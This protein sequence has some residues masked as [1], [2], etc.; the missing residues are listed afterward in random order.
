MAH[1]ESSRTV[2]CGECG[3]P[4]P[5]EWSS[6][7]DNER[8]RCPTCGS[9]KIDV[10]VEL[11]DQLQSGTATRVGREAALSRWVLDR[12]TQH[13]LAI[14]VRAALRCLWFPICETRH[15]EQLSLMG[16]RLC[17]LG[18]L[19]A[20]D[21]EPQPRAPSRQLTRSTNQKQ[22]PGSEAATLWGDLS[23]V[24]VSAGRE[25]TVFAD[26]V[27][28]VARHA[29][30]II[31]NPAD[32]EDSWTELHADIDVMFDQPGEAL[33]KTELFSS[34]A[35][36]Y[37]LEEVK[38]SNRRY[39]EN[40]LTFLADWYESTIA[41]HVDPKLLTEV[42]GIPDAD[43]A[44]GAEHV[45]EVIAAIEVGRR[46]RDATPLAEEIVFDERSGKLCVGPVRM[47]PPSLYDT[48]LEKLQ[49]AVDDAR[50]AS[51]R[52]PN[53]YTALH[54]TLET[55]DRTL[56]KYRG[57]PQRVHDDQLLAIRKIKGLVDDSYV[58]DDEEIASLVQVLDTNAVDI[59]A[60]VPTVAVA[61][62]KRSEIRFR[63]LD[64]AGRDRVHSAV[65]AVAS[66]SEESLA[67]EMRDD[68]RATFELE[69][70]AQ[71]VESPYRLASRLAAAARTVRSLDRIVGF[72]ERHGPM[73]ASLGNDL[74]QTL[75]TFIG[76]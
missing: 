60:A 3:A 2:K 25:P 19:A 29:A 16:F 66:N 13:G 39:R 26:A 48:G 67:E 27:V 20:T 63:E 36:Q 32:P 54:P 76:L 30:D 62:Q 58:P 17:A 71:D 72:A 1:G 61:V 40:G 38:H 18:V 75:T 15:S 43:W 73:V 14:A 5:E 4:L 41:G 28:D 68:E 47:L 46:L 31:A 12:P 34:G 59:R 21:Q 22:W 50:A 9:T 33:L 64:P 44:Q 7:D 45:A 8:P 10:S 55:L 23:R 51:K 74:L 37:I 35:S 56:T 53:S 6:K 57:N 65:E 70:S 49:D 11:D 52:D 24:L 42:V 69:R